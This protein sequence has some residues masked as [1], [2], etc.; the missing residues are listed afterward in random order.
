MLGL[1]F[2]REQ[3]MEH[4]KHRTIIINKYAGAISLAAQSAGDMR[5]D[6]YEQTGGVR[7]D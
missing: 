6:L 1:S 3:T 5:A 4:V 2:V 7:S